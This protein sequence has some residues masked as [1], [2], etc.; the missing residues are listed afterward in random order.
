MLRELKTGI[1]DLR[2]TKYFWHGV[3]VFSIFIFI[4]FIAPATISNISY[5]KGKK[6]EKKESLLSSIGNVLGEKDNVPEVAVLDTGD[7][8]RRMTL[9]ANNP[10]QPQPTI[11]K[12]KNPDGTVTETVIPANPRI[13]KWPVKTVYPNAGALL[14]FNRIVAYYGNLYSTKMGVLGEYEE[15]IMLAKLQQEVEK[16]KLADSE[17]P[18]IPALHYIAV[19]AQGSAGTD[20][21]YRFRMPDTEIDKVLKMAEKINA[22]VFIDIQVA[23]SDIQTEL[24]KFEKY[25][26]MPNVHLG[27]DPEFSMKTGAKPGTV[28]GTMDGEA[29]VN[30][31]VNYLSKIV[32]ENNLP[33]KILIVHRYTK[34]ML[35]NSSKIKPTPEVQVVINMDGWGG[36]DK[37]IGTYKNFIVPEPVQFAGFKLFYKNDIKEPNTVIFEPKELMKLNPRPIYIQY[38]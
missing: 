6:E 26:K 33:P 13:D 9:L 2:K 37:K 5:E 32:Q 14:P 10:P 28:V 15:D 31:S 34:K 23:L 38:Q 35:T 36:K 12:V 17:T 3:S 18:V 25:L 8:D 29:D 19:V 24:P 30:Y 1:K 21:K 27:I 22:I 16:W 4:F 20:G 11:K 7:Y